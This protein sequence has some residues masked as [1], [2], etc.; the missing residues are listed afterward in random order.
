MATKPKPTSRASARAC[1]RCHSLK[2][3]CS[4]EIP[5]SR[6]TRLSLPCSNSRAPRPRG[7]PRKGTSQSQTS[8]QGVVHQTLQHSSPISPDRSNASPTEAS[9]SLEDLSVLPLDSEIIESLLS[10]LLTSPDKHGFYGVLP[11]DAH[12][13]IQWD[14]QVQP[15][16]GK[17]TSPALRCTLLA[18]A[19]ELYGYRFP[20]HIQPDLQGSRCI[21]QDR[22]LAL[23][24]S[25]D[26]K[27]GSTLLSHVMCLL[28][29]SYTWCMTQRSAAASIRWCS[30]AK[31]NFDELEILSKNCTSA[32]GESRRRTS[33]ALRLQQ[34]TLL[35]THNC[36]GKWSDLG[37]PQVRHVED[38]C[39]K[40]DSSQQVDPVLDGT[41]QTF[42]ALFEPL[43]KVIPLTVRES[44]IETPSWRQ[45]KRLL[46]MYF[47]NFPESL[48]QFRNAQ[49][50]YQL[51]AMVWMHGLFL[52]LYSTRD[53]VDLLKNQT[54]LQLPRFAHLLDHSLLLGEV[55]PSLM[56]LD[57][58]LE[59]ISPGTI[60]FVFLSCIIQ[61]LALHQF[62][63][64]ATSGH[65]PAPKKLL[66]S[67]S[68]HLKLIDS[69]EA[70]SRKCDLLVVREFQRLLATTID[71]VT[72]GF[73]SGPTMSCHV[74]Y[75][76]RWTE[77]G[78]GIIQ[79]NEEDGLAEW[80]F[81]DKPTDPVWNIRPGTDAIALLPVICGLCDD[82]RRICE[83]GF[84]DLSISVL[85]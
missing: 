60:Y 75:L 9:S 12:R 38:D 42:F 15:Q 74:L 52:V 39:R 68:V 58:Y 8:P 83:E 34:S 13:S 64:Q 85:V 30:L 26:L 24:T 69:L 65:T 25:V 27:D 2:T 16:S 18:V 28:L 73:Y 61:S 72:R 37:L 7:R 45:V 20:S 63:P 67:C 47:F 32:L 55:L 77:Q 59:S 33:T 80:G 82:G 56:T 41:D 29:L 50:P 4:F 81:E 66:E 70:Y 79:L 54:Y 44:K 10:K 43:T 78:S 36:I 1:D 62:S 51:E 3:Q 19:L 31:I 14:Y 48:L 76:Y 21:L 6:C 57:P 49:Y 22:A 17:S 46:E 11:T 23:A 84:F 40:L 35:L 5:C 53:F 71:S